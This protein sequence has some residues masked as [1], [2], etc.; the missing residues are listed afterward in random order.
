M[1]WWTSWWSWGVVICPSRAVDSAPPDALVIAADSGL[2]HAVAAGIEPRMLV[3]DLDSISAGGRMWA[4]AH[5]LVIDEHP[6]DKDATD[7]DLALTAAV[8][9]SAG[10]PG[11]DRLLVLGGAG[12]RL[13]HL[14]GTI[15]RLGRA[16]LAG[17]AEVRAVLGDAAVLIAHDTRPVVVDEPAGTTFS[18]L[19]LH[20]TCTGVDVVGA[21][22]PLTG[23][24]LPAA[25]TLGIS[26]EI[27][28]PTHISVADGVLTVVIP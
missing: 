19:A 3:G 16:D 17:F 6:A 1:T 4:Y 8:A 18:L 24:T 20:G 13:D 5:D 27:E 25:A 23:A 22:W 26:N 15:T 21:R 28:Q 12:D 7:T 9:A 10:S 2:D 11:S 14:I